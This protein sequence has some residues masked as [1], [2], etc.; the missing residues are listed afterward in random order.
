[1]KTSSV[2]GIYMN[3]K[4]NV[5]EVNTVS[6]WL[7]PRCFGTRNVGLTSVCFDRKFKIHM[8]SLINYNNVIKIETKT[9]Q[10]AACS[11]CLYLSKTCEN[12]QIIL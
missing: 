1:M 7:K 6:K 9:Q 3:I 8:W 4:E 12:F 10:A 2:I 5:T 11:I